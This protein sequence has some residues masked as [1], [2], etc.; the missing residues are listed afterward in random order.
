M[1]LLVGLGNP[2][3]GHARNRH[4]LGFMAVDALVR[5]H[6]F[7]KFR[8]RFHGHLAEGMLGSQRSLA[9]KPATYMNL[10]GLAVSA[11]VRFYKL[12]LG[13]VVV[14]H[15]EID[16]RPGKVRVKRGGSAAGHNGLRSLDSHLGPGYRRVRLG[17]GHPGDKEQVLN[18]LLK[19]FAAAD[20][21]WLEP[22]LDAVVE[23]APLLALGDDPAFMS[24]VA[25]LT[26]PPDVPPSAVAKAGA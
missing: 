14:F 24:K 20:I 1:L 10:S 13:E 9:L 16:L 23:A 4:N 6:S 12:A 19:D 11:A 15:D 25:L 21:A 8:K 7:G 5:R 17:V 3:P 2:G 18:H 22:L 26:R